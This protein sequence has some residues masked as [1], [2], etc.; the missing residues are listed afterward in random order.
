MAGESGQRPAEGDALLV[1]GRITAH[2]LVLEPAFRV[3]APRAPVVGDGAYR[4]EMLDA[5]GALLGVWRFE[6]SPLDHSAEEHFAL[7]APMAEAALDRLESLRVVGPGGEAER[8]ASSPSGPRGAERAPANVEASRMG[9]HYRIDWDAA[10]FPAALVRDPE[11]GR[12][13][14][15][16]RGG[17]AFVPGQLDRVELVLSDGVGSRTLRVDLEPQ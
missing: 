16:A 14:S 8:T 1:W 15:I 10:G 3:K 4:V 13:L 12:V 2:G 5:E 6:P 7:L 9:D 17:H 11:T